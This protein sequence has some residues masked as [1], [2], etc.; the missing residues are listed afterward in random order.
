LAG[1]ETFYWRV[2]SYG[3][4]RRLQSAMSSVSVGHNSR[5]LTRRRLRLTR[6]PTIPCVLIECGYLSNYRE[7]AA[8]RTE[9]YRERLAQA[10]ASAIQDQSRLGDG[11]V[12][13]PAARWDPPSKASDG[14]DSW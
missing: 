14:R 11:A 3:L 9:S 6:N 13:L 2:D 4:A 5:G 1:P 7:A 8:I 12:T 10:I